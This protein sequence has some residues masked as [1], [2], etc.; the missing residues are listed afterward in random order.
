MN[1]SKKSIVDRVDGKEYTN[2]DQAK[3][4]GTKI[5]NCGHCGA[6]SNVHDVSLYRKFDK[7]MT[8]MLSYCAIVQLLLGDKLARTCLNYLFGFTENCTNIFIDNVGCTITHCANEC[9]SKRILLLHDFEK[10]MIISEIP[11]T[12]SYI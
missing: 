6:C 4:A 1:K 3:A 8:K 10:D 9:I 7:P 2:A 12:I 11:F 5:I